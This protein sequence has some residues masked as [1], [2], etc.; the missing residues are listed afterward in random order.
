MRDRPAVLG[1]AISGTGLAP[2]QEASASAPQSLAVP[3]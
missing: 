2:R 3:T 1:R